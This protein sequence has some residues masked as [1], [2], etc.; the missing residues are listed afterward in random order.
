MA[1]GFHDFFGQ[2]RA[3]RYI[4]EIAHGARALGEP[5]PHLLLVGPSG[6]GKTRLAEAL[7]EELDTRFHR[8]ACSRATSCAELGV[9][10]SNWQAHDVLLLDEVHALVP[11]VQEALY[12]VMTE[13]K[14]PR[15]VDGSD[16]KR[17]GT[18]GEIAIPLVTVVG[19][20]DRP[21]DLRNAFLKRFSHVM[22]FEPYTIDEMTDITKHVATKRGVVLTAQAA[23]F[24]AERC[25][26][27]P[28]FAVHYLQ[29]LSFFYPVLIGSRRI[30]LEESRTFLRHKGID[31]HGRTPA[32]RRY[33]KLLADGSAKALRTRPGRGRAV[34]DTR[35]VDRDHTQGPPPDRSR[36]GP[37]E[38]RGAS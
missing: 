25:R 31:D 12:R 35:K 14:A 34:V 16:G 10:A 22:E 38:S 37:G 1:A 15:V 36:H 33:M 8:V 19:A 27:I 32:D 23:R 7:A 13:S 17:A 11:Q 20:T 30:T 6:S 4:R 18:E 5:F 9:V 28:R 29:Q 24:L 26:G 2:R 21:G 3:T